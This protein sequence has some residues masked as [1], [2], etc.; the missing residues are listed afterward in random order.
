M[1]EKTPSVPNLEVPL[2]ELPDELLEEIFRY[3]D[4]ATLIKLSEV[5]NRAK[6]VARNSALWRPIYVKLSQLL[7]ES[8]PANTALNG[9]DYF[10]QIALKLAKN[11]ALRTA[12]MKKSLQLTR[13]LSK[14][15]WIRFGLWCNA[16]SMGSLRLLWEKRDLYSEWYQ[17]A[18][19]KSLHSYFGPYFKKLNRETLNANPLANSIVKATKNSPYEISYFSPLT[20]LLAELEHI[21]A[22][23]LLAKAYSESFLQDNKNI[24]FH[25]INLVIRSGHPEAQLE[26]AK[27]FSRFGMQQEAIEAFSKIFQSKNRN[28]IL[29][30]YRFIYSENSVNLSINQFSAEVQADIRIAIRQY[31]AEQLKIQADSYRMMHRPT[32]LDYFFSANPS[33]FPAE[34]A[35]LD[36]SVR[37][38]KDASLNDPII[39]ELPLSIVAHFEKKFL[40]SAAN[41]GLQLPISGLSNRR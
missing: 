41:A 31:L 6:A 32:L 30:A 9:E 25:Y 23:F 37:T 34:I 39:V 4:L 11:P 38:I 28:S 15:Q 12:I 13:N 14:D 3:Q 20:C 24:F 18:Y 29:S 5:S 16:D 7:P 36:N 19:A 8:F 33:P 35:K 40:L 1:P 22:A 21:E 10:N 2:L 26:L 17:A 27:G